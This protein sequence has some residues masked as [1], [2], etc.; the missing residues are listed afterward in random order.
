MGDQFESTLK[1]YSA[2]T[3]APLET[4][5]GCCT[6]EANRGGAVRVISSGPLIKTL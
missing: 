2:V 3:I 4:M 5:H 1:R 6:D